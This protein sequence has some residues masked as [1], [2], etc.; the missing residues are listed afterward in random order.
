[1]HYKVKYS[2]EVLKKDLKFIEKNIIQKILVKIDLILTDNPIY[3]N[4][5]KDLRGRLAGLK[6]LKIG[7]YR[8]IYK[9]FEEKEEVLILK[10]SHRKDA[11][12]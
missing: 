8:I 6:R 4:F 3:G 5:I 7:V 12:K 11:Y 10:I 2:E 9:V 1:M